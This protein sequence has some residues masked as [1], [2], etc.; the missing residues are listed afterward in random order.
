[1]RTATSQREYFELALEVLSVS[2]FECVNIGVLCHRLG[3][4]SGSFYHHFDGW[5]DFVHRLL[6][7]WEGEQ[8]A[9]LLEVR[10]GCDGPAADVE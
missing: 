10:F 9:S 4:T 7:F 5:D 8:S 3:V 6:D 1:M 2:G